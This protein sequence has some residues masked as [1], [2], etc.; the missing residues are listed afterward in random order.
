MS[1]PQ[2]NFRTLD[3]NLLRV[4]D[5]LMAEGSLTRAAGRLAMTQP[6][7]S[8]ALRRLHESLGETL[9]ERSARGMQPTARAQALWPQVR[10][11]LAGLQQ[12]LAPQDFDPVADPVN[13]RLAMVDATAVLLMPH[14]IATVERSG[15]AVNFRVLPLTT[16]DP[17]ALLARGDAD[18]AVGHFPDAITGLVA[19]GDTATL[20]HQQLY[21]S[22]YVCVMRRTHP[23]A[24][25]PLDL[26]AYCA[27]Q[28]LLVSFSGRPHGF[29]DQALLALGRR[30]RIVLTVNQFYTAGQVVAGSDLLTVLPVSFLGATGVPDAL[31]TRELPFA[32]QPIQVAMLWHMRLD[33]VPA[34]AWLRQQVAQA[35][36]PA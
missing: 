7:A 29:V 1:R 12:A 4:F 34:Q 3:L 25:Q 24:S 18:L 2:A 10:A 14:L 31:V 36:T 6:A 13:F 19:E 5:T 8:H 15:A 16:R 17:R 21:E 23:L 26:D 20:R 11:A 35:P 30:R 28:H 27:A 22:R 32:L 33:A 9:F